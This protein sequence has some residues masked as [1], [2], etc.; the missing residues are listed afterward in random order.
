VMEP[1]S[2]PRGTKWYVAAP[3]FAKRGFL[4][5][6]SPFLCREK[7]TG[8]MQPLPLPEETWWYVAAY[9]SAERSFVVYCSPFL[10]RE[11]LSG[12]IKPLFLLK[13]TKWYIA[14]YHTMPK[15]ASWYDTWCHRLQKIH[16]GRASPMLT[17]NGTWWL[18]IATARF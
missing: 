2:L 6:C 15:E 10:C 17:S 16:G 9:F 3:S 1:L 4:V 18:G 5:Y 12:K 11:L 8:V 13:G 7:L 14:S